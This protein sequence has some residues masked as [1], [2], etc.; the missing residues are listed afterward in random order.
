MATWSS[1]EASNVLILDSNI[2]HRKCPRTTLIPTG[3][4][5]LVVLSAPL[6]GLELELLPDRRRKHW[7]L[8]SSSRADFV[9][10]DSTLHATHLSIESCGGEW[11]VSSHPDCWGFYV[12][13]EPVETAVVEHGDRL[14]VGRH[15]LIFVGSKPV[16]RAVD[17]K[18]DGRS[19]LR[20]FRRAS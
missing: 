8:G 17:V 2:V 4:A 5:R 13:D 14:R 6:R 15:E 9:I 11:L 10:A 7:T 1:R 16:A 12:N 3:Q 20:W 18:Q 19:W